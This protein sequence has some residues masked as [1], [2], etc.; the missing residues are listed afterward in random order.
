MMCHENRS[1]FKFGRLLDQL[2]LLTA[3]HL[4]DPLFNLLDRCNTIVNAK[5]Q[6][7]LAALAGR[8]FRHAAKLAL[9][10]SI[11][12]K[13]GARFEAGD[14]PVLARGGVFPLGEIGQLFF[15]PAN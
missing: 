4:L 8:E 14:I 1:V 3:L 11:E 9:D 7:E 5:F 6:S 10:P 2:D 13:A 12:G 15:G